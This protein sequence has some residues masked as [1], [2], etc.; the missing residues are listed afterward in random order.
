MYYLGGALQNT[1]DDYR[2]NL[3]DEEQSGDNIME[4]IK[5]TILEFKGKISEELYR[6]KAFVIL[7]P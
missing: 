4:I 5:N 3:E 2:I 6:K 1:F 7:S